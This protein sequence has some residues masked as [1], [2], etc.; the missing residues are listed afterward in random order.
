MNFSD[1]LYSFL[2]K[3]TK[4]NTYTTINIVIKR[5]MTT[6]ASYSNSILLYVLDYN[7][8]RVI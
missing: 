3:L 5:I 1:L 6:F 7:S 4:T 2:H 8:S